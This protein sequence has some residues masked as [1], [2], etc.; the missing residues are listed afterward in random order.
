MKN[1]KNQILCFG[2]VLIDFFGSIKEGF[3][4]KLGGAPANVAIGLKKMN[5]PQVLFLGKVGQDLFGRFLVQSLKKIEIDTS[6]LISSSRFN[7]TLAYVS[8]DEEGQR[9]FSFFRGAHEQISKEEVEK[10]DLRRVRIL[11]FGSLTQTNEICSK[12]TD[13]LIA[14]AKKN[15]VF[16]SYDPNVRLPL[17]S[18]YSYL[19]SVIK[20]TIQKVDLLKINE[21]ELEF[22]TET[23]QLKKGA[24][25]LWKDNLKVLIVTL[26]EK[27]AFFKTEK[28]EGYIEGEK[29]KVVDTTGAGDAFNAGFLYK[30][31]GCI[32]NGNLEISGDKLAESV[33]FA[34][35]IA[36]QSVTV[37]GATDYIF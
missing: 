8:L 16:V 28:V 23:R 37:K 26:G 24:A 29:V 20:Q 27:G 19:K 17:W 25:K 2:E 12:A 34:N 33:Q 9:D 6:Y 7:T 13:F 4:P 15:K 1:G 31:S 21:E 32:K 36:S 30:I 11:Q 14:A 3:I 22:L 35:R 5:Y 10:V 18:D